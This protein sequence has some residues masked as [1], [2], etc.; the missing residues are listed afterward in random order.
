V[1]E[2]VAV[3]LV[4]AEVAVTNL[5]SVAEDH[6]VIESLVASAANHHHA[7]S[8]VAVEA[9]AVSLAASVAVNF[10][11]HAN[12]VLTK[13]V[14]LVNRFTNLVLDDSATNLSLYKIS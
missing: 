3:V 5:A 9:K 4:A 14:L 2:A 7:A 10:L 12:L 13:D 8:S 1:Q 11:Q 6:L